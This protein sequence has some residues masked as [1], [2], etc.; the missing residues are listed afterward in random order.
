MNN[1]KG[2]IFNMLPGLEQSA[3][4][5]TLVAAEHHTTAE[6]IC[7]Q[8]AV[9][10]RQ[11]TNMDE[12]CEGIDWLLTKNPE[13]P[14]VLEVMTDAAVDEQVYRDYFASLR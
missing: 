4:R 7:R 10:Y 12:M 1:G 8:N 14:M 3:A 11:A 6:G 13:R 9:C 2:A 5:D